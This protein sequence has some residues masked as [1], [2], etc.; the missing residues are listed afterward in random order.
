[1]RSCS[2]HVNDSNKPTFDLNNRCQ[3]LDMTSKEMPHN[4]VR[5]QSVSATMGLYFSQYFQ[6]IFFNNSYTISMYMY[7]QQTW[8]Y[9]MTAKMILATIITFRG[10]WSQQAQKNYIC[11]TSAQRLQSYSNV[12]MLCYWYVWTFSS[13]Y[14]KFCLDLDTFIILCRGLFLSNRLQTF[15][16]KVWNLACIKSDR[17]WTITDIE[18]LCK[19]RLAATWRICILGQN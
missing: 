12:Q 2:W 15:G 8:T 14:I 5:L 19:C 7:N 9:F 16:L 1:M 11:T 13:K 10:N 18:H 3:L 6:I 4:F 17:H